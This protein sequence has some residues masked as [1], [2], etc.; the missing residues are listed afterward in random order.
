M[1]TFQSH[2]FFGRMTT[3]SHSKQSIDV[4]AT[5]FKGF[6]KHAAKTPLVL[7]WRL[8]WLLVSNYIFFTFE[9]YH[10]STTFLSPSFWKSPGVEMG[11]TLTSLTGLSLTFLLTTYLEKCLIKK[12]TF[13]LF[14]W[15]GKN[16]FYPFLPWLYEK[17]TLI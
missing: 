5:Y 7:P 17:Q 16:T 13:S 11:E 8:I 6:N 12:K 10:C 9:S 3:T 2:N 1:K 14:L 4:F 15:S